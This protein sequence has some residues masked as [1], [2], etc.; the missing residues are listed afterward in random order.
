MRCLRFVLFRV[1]SW[2]I[3][4]FCSDLVC[5]LIQ[6]LLLPRGVW[7]LLPFCVGAPVV[8]GRGDVGPAGFERCV[9][10]ARP[11][12]VVV[13][14]AGAFVIVVPSCCCGGAPSERM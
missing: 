10:G 8:P 14:P 5:V 3:S 9:S 6:R 13:P 4:F 11:V 2:F 7:L 1:I 12:V